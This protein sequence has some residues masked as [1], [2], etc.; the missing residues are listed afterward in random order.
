[1]DLN[2]NYKK[3]TP[4]LTEKIDYGKRLDAVLLQW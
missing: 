2:S 4:S 1:M 3:D